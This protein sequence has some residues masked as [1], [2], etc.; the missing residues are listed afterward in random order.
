M[1]PTQLQ[2]SPQTEQ[3]V[4]LTSAE[5]A[6]LWTSYLSDTLAVCTIGVYLQHVEDPETQSILEF[7]YQ[8]S[9]VHVQKLQAFFT[10]GKIPVPDGFQESIDTHQAP[11][12]YT[13]DFYLFYIE[14]IGKVGMRQYTMALSNSAR[15]DVSQYF[16]DCLNESVQIFNRS[17]DAL[18]A[19]GTFIRA[20]YIPSPTAKE[21]VQKNSYMNT[22]FGPQR[23]LNV[24]EISGLYFNLI[25]NQ[26]GRSLL[27]GFSQTAG[28]QQIR[29]YMLRGRNIADKHVEIF[30]SLLSDEFIPSASVWDTL[31]TNSTIPPFSDK[32]MMFQVS[33]L[34]ASGIAHYGTSLGM[35]ARKD[36]S[37][38]YISLTAEVLAFAEDGAEI[39]IEHGW[40]EQPPQAPDRNKLATP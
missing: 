8:Q 11:R 12:L 35:S 27:M 40:M 38:R 1:T 16:T 32:M 33:A 14:N 19:K 2:P 24:I 3:K 29:N 6:S 30:G 20:P 5:I 10:K 17:T 28:T 31:P 22:W 37:T 15:A 34:N 23:A 18:L 9:K 21:Y 25:Q 4:E 36:L 26:L 13:D 7:A 39:M